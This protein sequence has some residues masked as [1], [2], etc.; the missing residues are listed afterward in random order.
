MPSGLPEHLTYRDAKGNTGRVSYYVNGAL[1]ALA[2]DTAAQAIATP[3]DALTNAHLQ[4]AIGP[5]TSLPTEVIYGANATYGSIEDKAIFTFQTANGTIHRV[6]VPAPIAAIFLADGE[7]IDTTNTLVVAFVSAYIANAF[8]RTG[9]AIT[10]GAQ[11][12]RIRRKMHRRANIFVL[13][14]SL[15]GTEE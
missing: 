2:A 5:F 14:P 1:G 3:L 10:F 6:Q 8:S 13:D 11:G 9:V 7:T 12:T 4:Q 15:V